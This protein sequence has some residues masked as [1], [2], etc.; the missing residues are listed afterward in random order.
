MRSRVLL[1]AAFLAASLVAPA[2]EVDPGLYANAVADPTRLARDRERDARE[3][4]VEVLAFA[5]FAPGMRV[6]DIFAGGG[7]YS[8]LIADVVG[9]GG[10]VL[11]LN[12]SAYQNF[13]RAELKERLEGRTLTNVKPMTV[14]SCNLRLGVNDL[15]AALIVLSYHDLYYADDAGGWA[16]IESGQFLDQIH[17]ALKPGGFFLIIDHAAKPGT[18]KSSAQELHRID[19]EFAKLDIESHGFKLEKTYDGLR[20]AGDDPSKLVFDPA[21]R[22]KTDRFVHLYRRI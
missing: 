8:E 20:T 14:E 6:A 5:G 4:P 22:G 7:Y 15:D 9:P 21:V 12:N 18:G 19:E 1:F 17:A 3:K 13:A 11:M 2:G 16:A 10:S